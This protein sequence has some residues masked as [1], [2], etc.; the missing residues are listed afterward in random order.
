MLGLRNNVVTLGSDPA[1]SLGL[2]ERTDGFF[3]KHLFKDFG[4]VAPQV[5]A[6][7]KSV[8]SQHVDVHEIR[9]IDGLKKF[10]HTYHVLQKEQ[11]LAAKHTG[12]L[13]EISDT[14]TA[15]NLICNRFWKSYGTRKRR[16]R[17]HSAFRCCM[18]FAVRGI[19]R[20]IL[21]D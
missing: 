7:V 21:D 20:G 6:L 14:F 16:M 8:K 3:A 10:I 9:D 4:A 1:K 13:G 19:G 5:E 17:T 2:D 12:L 11:A 15:E 18:R